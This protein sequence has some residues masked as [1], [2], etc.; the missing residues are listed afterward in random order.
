MA[1]PTVVIRDENGVETFRFSGG[2]M[3]TERKCENGN[4]ILQ[5]ENGKRGNKNGTV[6]FSRTDVEMELSVFVNM[7]FPFLL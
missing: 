6:T 5:N 2:K 3:E 4:G 7:E 1:C